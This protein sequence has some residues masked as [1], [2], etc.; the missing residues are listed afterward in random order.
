[1]SLELRD[2]FLETGPS[3]HLM[4]EMCGRAKELRLLVS[5]LSLQ[6]LELGLFDSLD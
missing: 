6:D 3:D 2:V 5:V 1:M 4:H